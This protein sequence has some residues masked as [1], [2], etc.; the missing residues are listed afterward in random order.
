MARRAEGWRLHRDE[1]HGYWYVR[2]RID[3]K[4]HNIS[5]GKKDRREAIEEAQRVYAEALAGRRAQARPRTQA[6]L[7]NLWAEWI[8][9]REGLIDELTAE[10]HE[11]YASATIVPFFRS[12]DGITEAR[13]EAYASWRLSSVSRS[14]VCKELSA[15]RVFVKWCKARGHIATLPHIPNPP[16]K[17]AGKNPSPKIRVELTPDQIEVFIAALPVRTKRGKHP[18]RAFARVMWETGLRYSTLT[19]IRTPEDYRRGDEA[20]Q[21]RAEI[22][23]ARFGRRLPLSQAA[24]EALDEACPDVGLIFGPMDL[25]ATFRAA[26]KAIGLPEREAQH[27]SHHDLRHARLTLWGGSSTDLRGMAY[28]AGHKHVTTT[29]LYIHSGEEAARGV[30]QAAIGSSERDER[31]KRASRTKRSYQRK[32]K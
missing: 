10:E 22:D 30:L 26:A 8:D 25:R 27:L 2:F 21:I 16:T 24:R 31:P 11:R 29:A 7:T 28:L 5:T 9:S 32:S 13:A 3:G 18:A 1:R 4:R 6:A 17:A 20:L 14:T 19:G 15:V 12:L 23:K